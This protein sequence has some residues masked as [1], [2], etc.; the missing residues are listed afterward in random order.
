MSY[1]VLAIRRYPVKSMAGE[2]LASEA[3][4]QRVQHHQPLGVVV[5][6][7][8]QQDAVDDAEDG[9]VDADAEAQT[10]DRD[11]GEGLAVPEAAQRV[12]SVLKKHA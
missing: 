12:A 3:R 7:R 8:F 1:D 10:Q 2:S 11:C 6:V 4:I 5:R 9:G